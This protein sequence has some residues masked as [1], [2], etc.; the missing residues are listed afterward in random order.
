VWENRNAYRVLVGRLQGRDGLKDK[1]IV[2]R[3]I[4]RGI[5]KK[6]DGRAWSE[7]VWLN[8]QIRGGVL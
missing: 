2:G 7:F 8:G 3:M 1:G 6:Q 5:L 4:L